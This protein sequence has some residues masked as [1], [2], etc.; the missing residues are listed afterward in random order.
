MPSTITA[1][2]RLDNMGDF[3]NFDEYRNVF[4]TFLDILI[5]H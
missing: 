1:Y 4:A 5:R 2:Y 3:Y